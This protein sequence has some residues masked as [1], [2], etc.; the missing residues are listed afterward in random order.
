LGRLQKG[1]N[2]SSTEMTLF[3]LLETAEHAK[4]QQI[5]KLMK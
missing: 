2:I 4:F 1:A 3:D 5:A